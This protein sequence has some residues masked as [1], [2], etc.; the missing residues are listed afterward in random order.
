MHGLL[1]N[2][3]WL[4]NLIT[5]PSWP[6]RAYH[7]VYKAQEHVMLRSQEN[8]VVLLASFDWKAA[9]RSCHQRY[10]LFF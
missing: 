1:C 8:M 3:P 2:V 6:T 7:N 10:G 5:L 4:S 9:V